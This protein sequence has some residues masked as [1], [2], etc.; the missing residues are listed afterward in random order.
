MALDQWPA[1]GGEVDAVAARYGMPRD[2]WLDLSTGINPNSYPLPDLAGEYWHRLPDADVDT[3]LREAAAKY[4]GV[5]DP[6]L[7]VPAPG[8]QALIRW[9]PRL[10]PHARV[11]ILGPTYREHQASWQAAGHTVEEVSDPDNVPPE[12][13]VVVAVNPNNPDGRVIDGE[14]L[15]ALAKDRLL[16]VDEAFAD[17][18]AEVS[19]ASRAGRPGLV[20]LRSVG[21]FFGLAGMRLGFALT[22]EPLAGD[23]RRA[24]GSWAVSGP[25]SA[26]GAVA[27]ADSA[28]ITA[29]RVRL[30]AAAGRLD[31]L[32]MRNRLR[33]AGGTTLFRLVDH[34]RAA[35]LFEHLAGAGILT[36]RFADKLSWLRIGIPGSDGSFERL[37]SALAAWR[38]RAGVSAGPS[39]PRRNLG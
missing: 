33:I 11:A 27:L 36:R 17:V 15:I 16:V 20:V 28:W 6:A 5:S 24:M 34:P 12:A 10:L 3:W 7:V 19:L 13:R 14:R 35:E 31:G 37:E 30:T 25:A 29:A 4:Y 2:R 8:S 32:L 9:L 26:V 39:T 1:H 38:P 21:K 22:G 18:M 23:L